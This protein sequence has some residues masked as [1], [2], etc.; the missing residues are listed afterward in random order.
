MTINFGFFLLLM[1]S[2]ISLPLS[3]RHARAHMYTH[4]THTTVLFLFWRSRR[5]W[6]EQTQGCAGRAKKIV[7]CKGGRGLDRAED[8]G[9]D[10]DNFFLSFFFLLWDRRRIEDRADEDRNVS[11]LHTNEFEKDVVV[12]TLCGKTRLRDRGRGC[13]EKRK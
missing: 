9:K 4:T 8:K 13:W 1:L 5:N 12:V 10:G 6:L 2:P 3:Q 7:G 11:I